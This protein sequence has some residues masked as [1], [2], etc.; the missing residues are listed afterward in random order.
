MH[1]V[2]RTRE[3]SGRTSHVTRSFLKRISSPGRSKGALQEEERRSCKRERERDRERK[4]VSLLTSLEQRRPHEPRPTRSA[5]LRLRARGTPTHLGKQV[6]SSTRKGGRNNE[7]TS[8]HNAL[9]L[10]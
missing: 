7:Q 4:R 3:P 1:I 2:P 9:S 8:K 5:L 6:R 10:S